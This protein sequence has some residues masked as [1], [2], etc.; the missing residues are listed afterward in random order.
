MGGCVFI[1]KP[2]LKTSLTAAFRPDVGTAGGLHG[3]THKRHRV[4]LQPLIVVR[5]GEGNR[6]QS[7]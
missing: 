3:L 4:V 1:D 6:E 2:Q 7:V 5:R